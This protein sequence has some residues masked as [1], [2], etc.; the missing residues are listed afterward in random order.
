[1]S[2]EIG[3][4]Q[5]YPHRTGP[6]GLP[7]LGTDTDIARAQELVG[8]HSTVYAALRPTEEAKSCCYI[9]CSNFPVALMLPCF[10]PHMLI[11][12]L[13]GGCCIY[14][15]ILNH[16]KDLDHTLYVVTNDMVKIHVEDHAPPCICCTCCTTGSNSE[17]LLFASTTM[18]INTKGRGCQC[19]QNCFNPNNA[20]SELIIAPLGFNFSAPVQRGSVSFVKRMYLHN[21]NDVSLLINDIRA[22]GSAPRAKAKRVFVA[23]SSDPTNYQVVMLTDPDS[24]C[25]DIS[26]K[27]FD[28]NLSYKPLQFT[29]SDVNVPVTIDQVAE[30]DK[31]IVALGAAS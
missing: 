23:S 29:L 21:A 3:R 6:N 30:N 11:L 16:Q 15:G 14:A 8:K 9:F 13:S 12:G 19:C 31:I 22:V 20:V 7:I 2:I 26:H 18:L 28:G 4:S 17:N 10:W 27:F 1:M 24:F 5:H 25:R